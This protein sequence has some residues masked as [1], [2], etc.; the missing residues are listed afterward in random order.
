MHH[1]N[2]Y[3]QGEPGRLP[4]LIIRGVEVGV[5]FTDG[6]QSFSTNQQ[7]QR[8]KVLMDISSYR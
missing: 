6:K 4:P 8:T 1:F 5:F 3:F 7:H 2:S